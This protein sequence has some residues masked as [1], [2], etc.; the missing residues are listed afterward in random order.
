MKEVIQFAVLGLGLAAIYSLMA[1][2]IVLI[3]RGSGVINF[4]HGAFALVGAFVYFELHGTGVPPLIAVLGAA[5][6]GALV[7]LSVQVVLMRPLRMAAPLTKVIATLGV[8]ILV[9]G[10]AVLKY[11]GRG[12]ILVKQY[13]PSGVWNVLGVSIQENRIILLGIAL[14]I[15]ILLTLG[16]ARTRLGLATRAAAENEVAAGTL[17]W[18]PNRLGAVSWGIGGALA[19]L[20]GALIVPITGLA[21]S[22]VALLVVPGLAAALLGRFNSFLK[23]FAGAIAI[24]VG[25]SLVIRYVSQPGAPEAF[26]FLV[27]IA[28]LVITGQS[29]PLRSHVTD[30]LPSLGSGRIRPI[31]A[32]LAFGLTVALML[33]AFDTT[34][35]DAF[36]SSLTFAVILLSIVVLTGYAGQISLAQ[37]AL[38]GLGAYVAGRLVATT[39]ISFLPAA[40]IG[41]AAAVPIGAIFAVPAVRTRGVNLAVI[42]LGLGVAITTLVFSNA[43]Y[44]GGLAGTNIGALSIFGFSLNSVSHPE[45]YAVLVLTVFAAAAVMVANLR[46]GA[47]GRRLI[48]IRGNERAAASLGISVARTKIYAFIVATALAALG[49]ILMAYRNESIVFSIFEPLESITA[50]AFAVIGGLGYVFGPLL[51]A[52]FV[53][54]GVG[55][56]FEALIPGIEEYLITIGGVLVLVILLTNPDGLVPGNIRVFEVL[57]T[58]V[59]P[60]LARA[61]LGRAAATLT[62]RLPLRRRPR[63]S[64]LVRSDDP[65]GV[66]PR[67]LAVEG[68]TVRFG[69]VTAVSDLS[70]SVA[71]GEIVGLIGPNGAGKTTF[72]D[73][74]TGFVAPDSGTISLAG[75]PVTRMS[76]DARVGA[77]MART[78]QSLE[79]FEDVSVLENLLVAAESDGHRWWDGL[80][81]LLRPGRPRLAGAAAAAV[82]EFGFEEDLAR[83]PS[84]LSYGRRRLAAIARSVALRP[85]VLLLDE[86]AAGLTSEESLELGRLLSRLARSW[87]MGLVLVEHDVDLVMGICDRVVVMNFGAVIATGTPRAVQE[88]QRVIDAYL[89]SDED[90]DHGAVPAAPHLDRGAGG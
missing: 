52:P 14:A 75:R 12:T 65:V 64:V 43:D 62:H 58:K 45:R 13:L 16:Q 89:G 49:G 73:A 41:I 37:Y 20:A 27:I 50:M 47:P 1:S 78:W 57:G 19:G 81:G 25:Q 32:T 18:S 77:G 5:A 31:P 83:L 38:A 29:L 86:P 34:W 53:A 48:A 26:P 82:A 33:F 74:V 70:L 72:I 84:D 30:R 88:D 56:L 59:K 36:T 28:V 66:D 15:T 6:A 7:G 63:P 46:R 85:S 8:L 68:L 54:G 79:L 2:G 24:G 22:T 61:D 44:T 23:A 42:T 87:G 69:A 67:P 90:E 21:I 11:G 40:V 17:G 51:G 10:I 71:P 60:L 80:T 39:D 55:S 4:A 3:Y 35:L 9:Q 76:A